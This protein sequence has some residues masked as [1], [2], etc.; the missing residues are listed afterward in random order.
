VGAAGAVGVAVRGAVGQVDVA[1]ED[2]LGMT[3]PLGIGEEDLA[4]AQL[5]TDAAATSATVTASALDRVQVAAGLEGATDGRCLEGA[6]V[7]W[8]SDAS[9]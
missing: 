5:A 3:R 8:R 9:T 2:D 6:D 4:V 7:D 1:V